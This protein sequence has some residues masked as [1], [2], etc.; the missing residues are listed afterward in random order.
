MDCDE[1]ETAKCVNN[2]YEM[3]N[4]DAVWAETTD[5]GLLKQLF[6]FYPTLHDAVILSVDVDREADTIQMVVDY[7]D[8]VGEDTT[9]H[10]SVRIRLEWHG[11][12]SFEIPFAERDLYFLDFGRRGN[13]IV[14]T[15]EMTGGIG[16]VV[17][18]H[19]E[20]VLVQMDPGEHD[21]QPWLRL[22]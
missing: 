3:S 6:G 1:S 12:E 9:Q 13:R 18:D 17:S 10:L 2:A 5:G 14:T 11:I 20:A 7:V 15:I 21:D 16:T 22:K 19:F 8:M 4:D